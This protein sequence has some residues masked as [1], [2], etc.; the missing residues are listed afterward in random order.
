VRTASHDLTCPPP[1]RLR[2]VHLGPRSW[3]LPGRR[4][5]RS[6]C[7]ASGWSSCGE[8]LGVVIDSGIV[9]RSSW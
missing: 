3:A 7:G 4:H 6:V 8:T 2:N 5:Q 9:E 1:D